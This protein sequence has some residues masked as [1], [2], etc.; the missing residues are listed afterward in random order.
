MGI[1]S[2]IRPGT[3]PGRV[4]DRNTDDFVQAFHVESGKT[5]VGPRAGIAHIEMI[6]ASC[7]RIQEERKKEKIIRKWMRGDFVIKLLFW[8]M[9]GVALPKQGEDMER[10]GKVITLCL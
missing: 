2:I 8:V 10:C 1:V 5:A 3:D 4:G 7:R 6:A 9:R